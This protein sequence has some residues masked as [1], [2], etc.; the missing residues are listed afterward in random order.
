MSGLLLSH[1]RAGPWRTSTRAET[2]KVLTMDEARQ[3]A[4]DI[5]K[6]TLLG[7]AR[8]VP[9]S[10]EAEPQANAWPRALACGTS[11]NGRL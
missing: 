3:V 1:E 10:L 5:A 6:P 11:F 7:R 4:A 8:E 9:I 2:A